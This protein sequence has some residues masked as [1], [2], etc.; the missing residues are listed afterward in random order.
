[1]EAPK[2]SNQLTAQPKS[3]PAELRDILDRG[4][5]GDATALPELKR[6]FDEHPALADMIGD[7]PRIALGSLLDAV[8]GVS[9]A[10]R[11]A[12][13]REAHR[14]SEELAGSDASL[15]LRLLADRVAITWIEVHH[16]D[17]ELASALKKRSAESP[18]MQAAERRAQAAQSRYLEAIKALA[19]VKKLMQPSSPWRDPWHPV[20]HGSDWGAA[21]ARPW[22]EHTGAGA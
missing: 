19:T 7:M 16:A 1:M 13:G 2:M 15:P 3:Y 11:E 17:T 12:I 5:A 4:Q 18:Q 14:L 21:P 10:A 8:A 20:P 9:L 6:A 22:D